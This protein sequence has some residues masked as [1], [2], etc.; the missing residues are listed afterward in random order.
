MQENQ[1]TFLRIFQN[2]YFFVFSYI[3]MWAGPAQLTRPDSAQKFSLLLWVR[4]GLAQKKKKTR[5]EELFPPSYPPACRCRRNLCW[6]QSKSGGEI[7]VT[8][9]R[10]GGALLVWLLRWQCC[11][12]GRWRCRGSRMTA[13]SSGA[14]VSSSEE[15]GYCSSPL[16]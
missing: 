1:Q 12:G 2:F 4:T 11:G 9:H 8:W 10:G 13:L 15:R 14:T 5:G 3:Y 6:K 16:L 7:R